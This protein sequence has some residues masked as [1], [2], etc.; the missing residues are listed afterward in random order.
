MKRELEVLATGKFFEGP[1][2]RDGRW[3]VSDFFRHGVYAVT[4]EGH[5]EKI[6][7]VDQQPSGIGWMPDGSMLVVSMKDRRILRRSVQGEVSVHADLSQYCGG[8]AN[9]MVVDR[10]GRAFVGNFGFD[11]IGGEPAV[12]AS[13]IRVD[14]NGNVHVAAENLYFP[15]GSVITPDGGALI[16][17]E[18]LGNRYTVFTIQADGRLVDRRVWAQ[19]G[20]EPT[21]GA[22]PETFKQIV[23][24]PDGCALDAEG[25]IWAAD[26][27]HG[28]CVRVAKGGKITE[29]IKAPDGLGIFACMLGGHDGRTLL[30][31]AST[32]YLETAEGVLLTTHVDAPHA[33]LP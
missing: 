9:D 6:W 3:W 23:V 13:L 27:F 18:S 19:F 26:A 15:N 33:G 5:S 14:P 28:R 10:H 17:G 30:L 31:C 4:P 22:L 12:P 29:E 25:Q 16:V 7:H 11:L 2:W 32:T 21:L 8:F 24:A 20:P 1:R